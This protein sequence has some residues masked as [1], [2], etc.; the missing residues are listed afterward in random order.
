MIL[1]MDLY[2]KHTKMEKCKYKNVECEYAGSLTTKGCKFLDDPDED[3]HN[4][5]ICYNNEIDRDLT[6]CKR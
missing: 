3:F 1:W 6:K 5:T 4:Y 2:A